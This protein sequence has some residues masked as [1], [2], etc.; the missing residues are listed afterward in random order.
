MPKGL[1]GSRKL[2]RS[3]GNVLKGGYVAPRTKAEITE[4]APEVAGLRRLCG[5]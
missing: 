2:L 4:E 1:L 3:L 5:I